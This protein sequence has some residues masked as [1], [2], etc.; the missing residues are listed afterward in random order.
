MKREYYRSYAMWSWHCCVGWMIHLCPECEETGL[1]SDTGIK[2]PP[3]LMRGGKAVCVPDCCS[4]DSS[5]SSA[6]QK[7]LKEVMSRVREVRYNLPDLLSWLSWRVVRVHTTILL[8]LFFLAE[9]KEVTIWLLMRC[10]R[11]QCT[12]SLAYGRLNCFQLLQMNILTL[13]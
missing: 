10:G 6:R 13:H 1:F 8:L 11:I 9:V 12:K 7:R 2:W 5:E 3:G 4:C